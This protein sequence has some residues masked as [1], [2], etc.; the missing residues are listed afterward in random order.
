MHVLEGVVGCASGASESRVGE[1]C[2]VRLIGDQL[3]GR[4]VNGLGVGLEYQVG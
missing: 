3:I 2:I 1:R 4:V